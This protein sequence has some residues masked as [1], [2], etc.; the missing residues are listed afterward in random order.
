MFYVALRRV[1]GLVMVFEDTRLILDIFCMILP[2][3]GNQADHG[4]VRRTTDGELRLRHA[5]R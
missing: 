3:R 1:A 2:T 4:Y 5:R